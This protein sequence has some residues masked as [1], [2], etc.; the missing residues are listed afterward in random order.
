MSI[1]GGRPPW[2][3]S[4]WRLRD[5]VHRDRDGRPDAASAQVGP[6]AAGVV[7]RVRPHPVRSTPGPAPTKAGLGKI[8]IGSYRDSQKDPRV[9]RVFRAWSHCMRQYG[10]AYAD[11]TQA[12]PARVPSSRA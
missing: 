7:R 10:Y 4:F 9:V 12:P 11:P 1:V 2:E 6:V 5:A 3:P 8:N